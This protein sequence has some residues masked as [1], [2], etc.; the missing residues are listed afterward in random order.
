VANAGFSVAGRLAKLSLDDF[1][2][3]METNIFGVLRTFIATRDDLLLQRGRLAVVGSVSGYM[4]APGVGA[5]T[6]SKFAVR[7]FCD[8]LRSELRPAGVSVTHV[9]PGFIESDLR[10]T[11]NYG[12][13]DEQRKDPI[14]PWL[15][16]P[17]AQAAVEIAH[18][19]ERRQA[20]R[21]LTRHGKLGVF[22]GR[23]LPGVIDAAGRFS[24]LTRRAGLP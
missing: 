18:A 1:R 12:R 3:Q 20:E 4:I 15:V 24:R 13:F 5:Y 8:T 2:R 9:I 10:Q 21:I 7:A 11:D 19:L 16:M 17:A 14:P 22:F 6:M 23:H